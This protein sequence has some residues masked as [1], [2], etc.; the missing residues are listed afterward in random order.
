MSQDNRTI[1]EKAKDDIVPALV[2][3]GIGILGASFLL[4]VDMSM[5]LNVLGMNMPAYAAIG[6]VIAA[7]DIAGAALHDFVLE[8]IPMLQSS[9][10][11]TYE[12]RLATPIIAGVSTYALFASTISKDVSIMNSMLL[13]AGSTIA[14]QYTYHTYQ[15]TQ[16]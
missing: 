16:Q 9:G 4:G 2:S 14:G 6:G 11:A 15:Q 8:K 1:L 5:N 10:I 7:S 12:N 3:G 13:G